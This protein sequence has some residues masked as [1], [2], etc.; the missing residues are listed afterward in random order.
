V[1]WAKS[2]KR[3]SL[4]DHS[5]DVAAVASAL[6]CLPTVRHRL[7]ALAGRW[8]TDV[9]ADRL[10]FFVGLHD[11]GKV[12]HGFQAKLRNDKPYAGHI[13]PLWAILG[14]KHLN[15]A[16]R[17]IRGEVRRALTA[18][19]WRSWFKGPEEEIE[20]WGVIL[21]HHGS[22]SPIDTVRPKPQL[23][24]PLNGFDPIA[25]LTDL[26]EMVAQMFP[27]VFADDHEPLPSRTRFQHAFA[28]FVTL[29]DWLGSDEKVFCSPDD[30]A[31]SGKERI[32]WAREKALDLVSRR[33]IDPSRARAAA[34]QC[35][36]AFSALFRHP[37]PRPPQAALLESPLPRPGQV[38]V[39][40]AETGSGK[41]E[42]ALIHFLRLFQAGEVDGLY[43]ALP[44]RAAAVQIH[45]RVKGIVSDWLDEAA[46]PVGLA[47][48]G[49]LTVDD[50]ESQRLPDS[51]RVLWPDEDVSDRAWAVE[52]AKRYLSGTVMIGTIDQLLMGGL[53]VRHAPLRSGPMLRL[54][55]CVD[56][57]HA[58]DAYMA[59]LL[60]NVLE[61]HTEA[62]GHAL[63]MSA[64]LGSLARMRLLGGRVE[65]HQAPDL[66]TAASLSYPS[67]QRTGEELHKL[68]QYANDL[69]QKRVTV[70]LLDSEIDHDSLM[71][72]LK[73]AA[74]SGATVL[75][76]RNRVDDARKIFLRLEEVGAPLLRCQGVQAPHHS[77]FAP[78][79]RRLLD[80]ALEQA[81]QKRN[82]VIAVTTQTAEQSLD[83]D[84]DWLVTDIAPGDVLL[85]RIGRLHRHERDRPAGFGAPH[86]TVLAPT[87]EQLAGTLNLHGGIERGGTI[88]GI[89]SVYE[90]IIGVLA[91]RA[92]LQK[93][94]EIRIPADNR[95]VVEAATHRDG[96]DK[97]A[98]DLGGVWP[99]HL[100]D[101]QGKTTANAGVAR[102][103]A[104][105]WK[106]PLIDNQ[107]IRDL[108]AE[109]RLELKDR[110]VDLEASLLGPFGKTVRMLNV[111]GW[112][113]EEEDA[114]V[115]EVTA[116]DGKIRFRLGSK[117]FRYDR[118]GLSA[119]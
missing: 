23:W 92:W 39:L 56:E 51:H 102:G 84:A 22:L 65:A 79:D 50:I 31:P 113:V 69:L 117:T 67:L 108:H 54:L 72:R 98:K 106:E 112:M 96:L 1:A 45:G 40:E 88:L 42:A 58:S 2:P 103:V 25:S 110:R 82:G 74:D 53:R 104:I 99:A 8:L 29:A 78:E 70:E 94:G 85:Q 76:I 30:G 14:R 80:E 13:A 107:P 73:K 5:I 27:D 101:V 68:P 3:I 66:S 55:L 7:A 93:H 11:A 16:H 64:T 38:T 34:M 109:T 19:Q 118:L 43:F 97:L 71:V 12:N 75:F 32:R 36:L 100:L 18:A 41:T 21:A 95:A 115:T 26:A 37:T 6:L 49:Y 86:I 20:F 59:E 10:C 77:R 81:F 47:V 48:P 62:G 44:T 28:G 83:I 63:L 24:Y 33:W 46:P 17:T 89:G 61:Q 57:V 91:T 111:P 116:R 105:D 90:N 9:D 35:D 52:N 4:I 87:P 114:V 15:K 119:E 60:R